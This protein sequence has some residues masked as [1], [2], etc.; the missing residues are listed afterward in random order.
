MADT[1]NFL[2]RLL[3]ALWSFVGHFSDISFVVGISLT[4]LYARSPSFKQWVK[5]NIEPLL[6]RFFRVGIKPRRQQIRSVVIIRVR[7]NPPL[8]AFV[9]NELRWECYR[10]EKTNKEYY[11]EREKKHWAIYPFDYYGVSSE[12]KAEHIRNPL[13]LNMVELDERWLEVVV[14]PSKNENSSPYQFV[15]VKGENF[16]VNQLESEG[17]L[18][19]DTHYEWE[20]IKEIDKKLYF[21]LILWVFGKNRICGVNRKFE[22]GLNE[23]WKEW[24]KRA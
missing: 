5:N 23:L 17:F 20:G 7:G 21:K 19:T 12:E 3:S 2:L 22:K 4:I 14:R 6:H 13:N 15:R 1:F 11:R 10:N 16:R 18:V 24:G 8:L 9:L